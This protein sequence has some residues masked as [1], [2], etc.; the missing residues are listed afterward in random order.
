MT[1]APGLQEM[2]NVAEGGINPIDWA[3]IIVCTSFVLWI[4][5]ILR[6]FKKRS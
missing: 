5:E 3:L 2:F 1:E 6:L 4:G